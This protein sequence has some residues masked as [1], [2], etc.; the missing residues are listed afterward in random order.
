MPRGYRDHLRLKIAREGEVL[1]PELH[2]NSPHPIF[3]MLFR[4]TL[5]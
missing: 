1:V 5:S 4:W 3:A 2:P